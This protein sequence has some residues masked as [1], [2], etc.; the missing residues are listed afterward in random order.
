VVEEMTP[1]DRYF[2]LYLLTNPNTTQI[3]IYPITKK[4]MAFDLGYSIESVNALLDRFENHH[5]RIR[6]NPETREI[7]ILNWGKYNFNRGGKPVEDCIWKELRGV[8]D[9]NLIA[10]IAEKIENKSIKALFLK[11]LNGTPHDTST[12]RGQK[13]KEKEKEKKENTLLDGADA[14]SSS[15]SKPDYKEQIQ[16]VWD[17]YLKT[18]DGF[19]KRITLTEDRKA[20]IKARLTE[21]NSVEDIKLAISNIRKSP[22]HCGDNDSGKFYADITFV[23]R[24]KSKLEEWIN[25]KPKV[26]NMPRKQ[27]DAEPSRPN[28]ASNQPVISPI[29][30]ERERR[31]RE[32]ENKASGGM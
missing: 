20:K 31:R 32:Q 8:K 26:I 21:G 29:A 19:F 2:Y 25:Y 27:Q 30:E 13:E 23:C 6:Y 14:P 4:Q 10:L 11:H 16:E 1:E 17:H 22:F 18:F 28:A 9:K 3:G 15:P 7:A 5:K 12:I 24:S